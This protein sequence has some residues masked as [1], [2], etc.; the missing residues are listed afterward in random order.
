MI[1]FET[2]KDAK[3][4]TKSKK[5]WLVHGYIEND[6]INLIIGSHGSGK[7]FVAVDLACAVANKGLWLNTFPVTEKRDVFYLSSENPASVIRRISAWHDYRKQEEPNNLFVTPSAT[8]LTE[9]EALDVA[10]EIADAVTDGCVLIIDTWSRALPG[11]NENSSSEITEFIRLLDVVRKKRQAT[12]VVV[13]HVT[14][15]TGLSRG[16][17]ALPAAADTEFTLEHDKVSGN[18]VLTLTKNKDG[19]EGYVANLAIYN[20]LVETNDPQSGV[21]VIYPVSHQQ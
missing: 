17:S 14:K 5:D 1:E 9:G 12:V 18:R 11:I 13:H 7:S 4:L 16:S 8:V 15:G 3:V 19:F 20:H 21:G 2:I 6:T 10:N